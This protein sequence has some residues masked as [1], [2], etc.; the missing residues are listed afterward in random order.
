MSKT[1]STLKFGALLSVSTCRIGCIVRIVRVVRIAWISKVVLV[2]IY[3]VID[4]WDP[5]LRRLMAHKLSF[6]LLS[7]SSM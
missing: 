7:A 2:P 4:L 3:H 5:G 1:R 6:P